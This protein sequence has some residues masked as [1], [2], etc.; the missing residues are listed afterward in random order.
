MVIPEYDQCDCGKRGPHTEC[1]KLNI[2]KIIN[3]KVVCL[4]GSTRF[5]NAFVE[6]SRIETLKGKIVLS[7]GLFGHL[8]ENFDMAGQTKRMLDKLHL[9]KIDIADEVLFLN[10]NG[11][12]GMGGCDELGYAIIKNKKISFLEEPSFFDPACWSI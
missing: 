6:A 1:G 5:Q 10:V 2:P 8:E 11:Y 12:I 4:C 9:R 7:V 3:P